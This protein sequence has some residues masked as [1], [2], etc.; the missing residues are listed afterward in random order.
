MATRRVIDSYT[1]VMGT[2][3]TTSLPTNWERLSVKT[4]CVFVALAAFLILPALIFSLAG[5]FLEGRDLLIALAVGT[6]G[7][8]AFMLFAAGI[9][10]DLDTDGPVSAVPLWGIGISVE[11][12]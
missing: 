8:P 5:N 12:A 3:A 1:R 7:G 6:I 4:R 9:R 10:R 2:P 11:A